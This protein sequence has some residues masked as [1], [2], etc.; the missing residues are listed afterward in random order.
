VVALGA[1]S[2]IARKNVRDETD[3]AQPDSEEKKS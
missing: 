1:L 2:F 3:P